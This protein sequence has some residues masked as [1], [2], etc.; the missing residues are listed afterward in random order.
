MADG[1]GSIFGGFGGG[2]GGLGGAG[3]M[4]NPALM[5]PAMLAAQRQQQ[6]GMAL[7]QQGTDISPV[8]SPWQSVARALQGALGGYEMGAAQQGMQQYA[9]QSREA[10]AKIYESMPSPFDQAPNNA[11]APHNQTDPN[12]PTLTHSR[13]V[14]AEP[15][16]YS[17]IYDQASASSSIPR[18]VL[19]AKDNVESGFNNDA[20]SN[21]GASGVPQILASTADNPGYDVTPLGAENRTNPARAIPFGANYLAAR[22]KALFGDQ[23][24]PT[25]PSQLHAA[26]K[27]A[28]DG[29][30]AYADKVMAQ[31]GYQPGGSEGK[32]IVATNTN[33][34]NDGSPP[35]QASLDAGNDF[36]RN[37]YN[38]YRQMAANAARSPFAEV[39]AMAPHFMDQAT[40]SMA[41][42]R[43]QTIPTA[44]GQYLMHDKWGQQPDHIEGR[45][46]PELLNRQDQD[47]LTRMSP[48]MP[49]ASAQ[50][51]AD[52][53]TRFNRQYPAEYQIDSQG[54]RQ[55]YPNPNI[56]PGMWVPAG[57]AGGAGG[58]KPGGA[59]P[60]APTGAQPP[61]T[62][63]AQP[64][65][66]QPPA[67]GAQPPA[68]TPGAQPPAPAAQPAL[69]PGAPPPDVPKE[70]VTSTFGRIKDFQEKVIDPAQAAAVQG[71]DVIA[72][73]QNIRQMLQEGA[74]TG[75][76]AP[77]RTQI[78]Q[79][80]QQLGFTSDTIK[81]VMGANSNVA[82]SQMM[83]KELFNMVQ[84]AA[85]NMGPREAASVV[86]ML[87]DAYP[88]LETD[89]NATD[90]MLRML[91]MTQVRN[92]DHA[93]ALQNWLGARQAELSQGG[94]AFYQFNRKLGGFE[95]A[96]NATHD[97][98]VYEASA[99]LSA[100]DW[101]DGKGVNPSTPYEVWSGNLSDSQQAQALNIASRFYDPGG[102]G[103]I[104]SW[105]KGKRSLTP[106]QIA[107]LTQKNQYPINPDFGL[108]Y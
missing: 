25:N 82:A 83:N 88:H 6:Y 92:Q 67:P 98:R 30:D 64:S 18:N 102:R 1:Q 33:G 31:A 51:K 2:A 8:K 61:P 101:H 72:N 39:R 22:G 108:D 26:L 23:W 87:R 65:G 55:V 58:F 28:G 36:A 105:P 80:M 13:N 3:W 46:S 53:S 9:Q 34:Q 37:M 59:Q 44:G 50:A 86:S 17:D 57:Y 5:D 7:L 90:A 66:A 81:S 40:Q 14:V 41:F 49:N 96:W 70:L 106:A 52:F 47:V 79:W 97:P 54:R 78:A 62:P 24:D 103:I 68:P 69:A 27:A 84:A 99:M 48:N 77:E 12:Q 19:V 93:N 20:V 63:G 42:N 60:P 94:D 91:E 85:R 107:Q 89:P 73:A 16:Q 104:T 35:G 100:K 43:W 11:V 4:G 21:T 29:T 32:V 75:V 10:A 74:T 71:R 56:P 76:M 45:V 38:T 95:Q 15:K